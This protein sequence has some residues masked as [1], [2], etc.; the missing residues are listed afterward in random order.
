M[1]C[2][3][4]RERNICAPPP[5]NDTEET[6]LIRRLGLILAVVALA[7]AQ[8][9]PTFKVKVDMVVLSFQITDSKGHYVNGLKPKDFRVLE[10]GISQKINTFSEGDQAPM[11]VAA[12]GTMQA[13]ALPAVEADAP[14]VRTET[15]LGTSVFVLFDT[16]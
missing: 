7:L 9:R 5:I 3:S 16:S 11:V 8:D 10:D 13:V 12:D 1:T 2:A 4:R 14:D 6:A 15:M